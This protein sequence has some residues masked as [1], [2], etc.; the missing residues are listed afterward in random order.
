MRSS[1]VAALAFSA[2]AT[3]S[4]LTCG[5]VKS[6]YG[7][8]CCGAPSTTTF[9]GC[10]TQYHASHRAAVF[11]TSDSVGFYVQEV[12][13]P[14]LKL[15]DH[16]IPYEIF[17]RTGTST[18]QTVSVGP[19]YGPAPDYSTGYW[20][21]C[22]ESATVFY[23]GRKAEFENNTPLLTATANASISASTICIFAGGSGATFDFSSPAYHDALRRCIGNNAIVVAICHGVGVF[24]NFYMP[25]ETTPWISGKYVTSFSTDEDQAAGALESQSNTSVL[26]TWSGTV[27]QGLR[28]MGAN[29]MNHTVFAPA[30]AQTGR[31]ITGASQ[32]SGYQVGAL[33]SSTVV[34]T[35]R[36]MDLGVATY[37]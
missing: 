11:L 30:T 32:Q 10:H 2:D 31:L 27:E 15:L 14:F 3:A 21:W 22:E 12:V 7:A 33:L 17:S 29:Y 28:A 36:G 20:P 26:K 25:G 23:N 18:P 9:T 35:S 24:V 5:E 4:S 16:G 8:S 13:H 37:V 6:A 1:L 34:A 19:C